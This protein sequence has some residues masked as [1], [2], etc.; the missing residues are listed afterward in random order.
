MELITVI[1][2][3]YQAEKFLD[4]CITSI[5]EQTYWNLEI[6]LI[7]D[8]STDDSLRI[9]KQWEQKDSRVIVIHQNNSGVSK[10]RNVGISNANG[11]YIMM[12]DSDDYMQSQMIER[13]YKIIQNPNVDLVICGFER[14]NQNESKFYYANQDNYEIICAEAALRRIYEDDEKALQYVVPWAKLYKQELFKD[15]CYPEGKIFEDIYVTHE[16]LFR[17]KKIAVMDAKLIYYYQHSESIMN[18]RF[19]AGKLDYL[20]ALKGRITFYKQNKLNE[21]ES[22]AYDEYLHSL[23]W[24]Y[25]R[26]RDILSNKTEMKK[27][28]KSYRDSYLIGYSNKRYPEENSFFLG[29]FELNPELIIIYWKIRGKV[30]NMLRKIKNDTIS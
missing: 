19:H 27:I 6:I 23:I 29:V 5:V 14:G 22:I 18:Q 11:K 17:C 4:R 21:L 28:K 8:G 13:M 10:A 30:N 20:D 1:V 25:S 2:P 15:I 16:I 26:A 24:E 7:D 3:I 9:C 12:L